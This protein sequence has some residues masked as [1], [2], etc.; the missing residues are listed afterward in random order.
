MST[1]TKK[2]NAEVVTL[3]ETIEAAP[4]LWDKTANGY[5]GAQKKS[6]AW[7]DVASSC[8]YEGNVF[9]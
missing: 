8:G 9:F 4:I 1:K 6:D 5:S 2:K 3:I 7:A